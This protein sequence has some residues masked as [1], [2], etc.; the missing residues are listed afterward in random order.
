[1]NI[2]D[3]HLAI[4]WVVIGAFVITFFVTILALCNKIA[5]P[6]PYLRALFVKM[7]LEVIAAG[8]FLFYTGFKKAP[9]VDISG[10]WKYRCSAHGTNYQHG[11]ICTIRMKDS[12][13]G[14][15]WTLSGQRLWT[16]AWTDSKTNDTIIKPSFHWST[17][18]GQIT[19]DDNLKFT[20]TIETSEGT[21]QGFCTGVI[22]SENGR[23]NFIRGNFYQLPPYRPLFG[24]LEF[25]RM[26]NSTD[27][28][29]RD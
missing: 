29:W 18:W 2:H 25:Q 22:R 4:V 24:G 17:S 11:G 6:R 20:Y 27:T 16:R 5:I 23:P 19:G 26:T 1:M 10:E 7:L 9:T 3:A 21:I 13:F 8:F 12:V 28:T 15:E 14:E